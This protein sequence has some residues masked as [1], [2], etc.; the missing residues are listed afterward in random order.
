MS[1][2]R[3]ILITGA[4]GN[5]GRKLRQHLTGR[6]PLRLVD[7]KSDDPAVSQADL[8]TW[9]HGWVNRFQGVHTVVHLAADPNA[10]ATWEKLVGPNMDA[11]LNV[12]TAAAQQGVKRVIYASSNHAMGGYKDVP[13]PATITTD[14]PPKPG[15]HYITNGE[16]RNSIAY[17]SA[18]LFGERIGKCYADSFGLSTIAVRIGWVRPGDNLA[19]EIPGDRET[20]FR[21]MWLSN[22]DFCHLIECCIEADPTIRFAVVNGMSANAGMRWDIE[23]TKALVGYQPQDNVNA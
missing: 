20:W 2:D 11:L 1:S 16:P 4:N 17:G 18:K 21:L 9:D 13:E 22:R 7:V 19:T 10:S 15:T 14:I 12:F 3:T 5:L 6:Y 8:A 23:H